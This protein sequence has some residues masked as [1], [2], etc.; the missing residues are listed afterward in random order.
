MSEKQSSYR[1]IFKATSLFGGVQVFNILI[2]VIRSKFVAVLLGT[3]GVGIMSL[4]QSTTSLISTIASLGLDT[5]AVREISEANG[6][7]NTIR[8]SRVI[9]VFRRWIWATGLF[10]ATITFFMAPWLSEWTFGNRDYT[11]AFIWLSIT[12]LF[13]ALSSGQTTLLHGL[14]KLKEM[15]MANMVGAVI[16]L[17]IS[18]PLYYWL[19]LKGIVPTMILSSITALFLTW[20]YSR[21]IKVEKMAISLSETVNNGLGMAK[22]GFLITLSASINMLMSYLINAFVSR[23][24][25]LDDVGLYQAGWS[26]TNK[27]VGLVFTAMVVDYFPRISKIN[28]DNVQVREVVNQQSEIAILILSPILVL[29]LSTAPIVIHILYTKDFLP[30]VVFIEWFTLGV[31]FRALGW[32]LGFIPLAKGDAKLYFWKEILNSV[33]ILATC[34]AGYY[35]GGLEGLGISFA[36]NNFLIYIIMQWICRIKYDFHFSSELRKIFIF[37]FLLCTLAFL[38]TYFLGF[39]W[40]YL[41]GGVLFLIVGWHSWKTLDNKMDLKLLIKN[42]LGKK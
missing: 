15:A 30:V 19:G 17:A 40:A 2:S 39:P 16:G 1:Q 14:Q 6:T 29:L 12:L 33:I 20:K 11:M 3:S 9:T 22:L 18:I 35:F 42:K 32:A 26:I 38:F 21:N 31:L 7:N 8:I 28:H 5:S 34:I 37:H 27:Y 10:G 23:T 25:S 24:G 13:G 41:S 4:L 36:I